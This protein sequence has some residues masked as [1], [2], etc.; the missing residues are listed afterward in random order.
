MNDPGLKERLDRASGVGELAPGFAEAVL[1]RS[2]RRVRGRI[3]FVSLAAVAG[4]ITAGTLVSVVARNPAPAKTGA[5]GAQPAQD[6]A[7]RL[8]RL[9]NALGRPVS[10]GEIVVSG[11]ADSS[12]VVAVERQPRAEESALRGRAAQVWATNSRGVFKQLSDYISYDFACT[13][14]DSEC[15][16]LRPSG[17]GFLA[18]L[19]DA[20]RAGTVFVLVNV[21]D[22]R[23]A[24]VLTAEGAR[25]PVER[26]SAGAVVKVRT[27]RPWDLTVAVSTSQGRSY[28]LPLPPGGVVQ[29]DGLG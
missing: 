26:S 24:E 18:V 23:R 12:L 1:A 11:V 10:P 13:V 21:P 16:R 14:G 28:Q 22:G 9:G 19:T 8:D 17:L 7:T 27:N 15:E 25:I 5:V 4:V 6:E 2:R 29:V 20:S 3:M